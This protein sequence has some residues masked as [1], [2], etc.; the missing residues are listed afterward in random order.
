MVTRVVTRVVTRRKSS[1]TVYVEALFE[2]VT[3]AVMRAVTRVFM[4]LAEGEGED[5]PVVEVL[6]SGDALQNVG[7]HLEPEKQ[8]RWYSE[9][10]VMLG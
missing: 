3:R 6:E 9:T 1:T 2:F 10:L 8:Q 4:R 5:R 7:V